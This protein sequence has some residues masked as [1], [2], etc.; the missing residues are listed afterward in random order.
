MNVLAKL[1]LVGFVV[2]ITS[3]TTDSSKPGPGSSSAVTAGSCT[4]SFELTY[5]NN[6]AS[7]KSLSIYQMI[8]DKVKTS[9][10]FK[11]GSGKSDQAGKTTISFSC[12]PKATYVILEEVEPDVLMALRSADGQFL[13]F[14]CGGDKTTC[15]LGKINAALF[16]R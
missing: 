3:C 13:S 8:D 5:T 7:N 10:E 1:A 6:P 11:L 2:T 15:D 12:V 4:V 16:G 9:K 14:E